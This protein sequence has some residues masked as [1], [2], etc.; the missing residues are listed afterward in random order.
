MICSR[1][2]GP[3]SLAYNINI[4][5][6][7]DRQCIRPVVNKMEAQSESQGTVRHLPKWCDF[8]K[9]ESN[10]SINSGADP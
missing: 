1:A 5:D 9:V 8:G 7:R 2:H 10:L 4:P 6:N 3:Q